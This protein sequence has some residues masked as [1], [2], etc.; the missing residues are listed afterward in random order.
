LRWRRTHTTTVE[1]LI[2]L[3]KRHGLTQVEFARRLGRTQQF[4]SRVENRLRRL[5][6]IEFYAYVRALGADPLEA[7]TELFGNLP[8]DVKL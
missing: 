8:P 5:D 2:E 6:V 4:V 7:I 3:R 1:F